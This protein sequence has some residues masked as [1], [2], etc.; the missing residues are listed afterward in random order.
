[1]ILFLVGI[2][3][4]AL[5]AAT[6]PPEAPA[7]VYYAYDAHVLGEGRTPDSRIVR[8]MVD[9][10]VM[11]VTGKP[12]VA[13]A[14]R[15]MISP[16]DVVGIKVAAE[17]GPQGGTREAVAA[18]VAAGLHA[19]G[20]PRE[21]ILVWDRNRAN[22]EA[23]GFRQDA[24]DYTLRW[25]D[26]TMGYD[27]KAQVN[28]PVLGKLVW[29]DSRFGDAAK[30]RRLSDLLLSGDQLSS[31]SYFSKILSS[32]VT[33]VIHIPSAT[34]SYQ[35]GVQGALAGM[36][37]SNLDNWRRFAKA[38]DP[39]LAEIYAEEIIRGKV[40]L[41]IL[42]ALIV[43]YAGG[44]AANPNFTV[45]NAALFAARDPVALD[46]LLVEMIDEIRR[47]SKLPPIRPMTGYIGSAEALG[48]GQSSP[49]RIRTIRVGE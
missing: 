5:P 32:E 10:L 48:L 11:G 18:A 47:A 20:I 21:R 43:Q 45:D 4:A 44:P 8:R 35:A 27:P 16:T 25:V 12:S 2:L 13:E 19:A 46:A 33:K 1:M 24:P 37:L 23:C 22:L 42:D 26:P 39:Y 17:A 34:D 3:A 31:Q 6:P 41:T 30:N 40:V 29:G 9:A 36:T 15:S 49:E 38:P 14:W 7:K 28:A